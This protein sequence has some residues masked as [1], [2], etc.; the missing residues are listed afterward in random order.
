MLGVI[1]L[2]YWLVALA[3]MGAIIGTFGVD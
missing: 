1:M 3:L 2:G